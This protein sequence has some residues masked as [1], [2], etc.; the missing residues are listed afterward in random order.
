ML[1]RTSS[2]AFHLKDVG[3]AGQ[4]ALT[5]D[6]RVGFFSFSL[7]FFFLLYFICKWVLSLI[8]RLFRC[9]MRVLLIMPPLQQDLVHASLL[10]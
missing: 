9:V 2:K 4:K 10:R 1:Y 8:V 7:N 6:D 5:M 3:N